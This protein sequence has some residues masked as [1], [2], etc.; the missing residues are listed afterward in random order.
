MLVLGYHVLG[1]KVFEEAAED[2]LHYVLGVNGLGRSF[3]TGLG[4]L[5]PKQIHHRPSASDGVVEPVPGL[6]AGGPNR[7]LSGD[8]V[9]DALINAGTP[10]ALCYAD[11]TPSYASNEIA[12]NWNAPLVFLAGYFSRPYGPAGG[13]R[14][15]EAA[16]QGLRIEQNFPNPFNGSTHIRFSVSRGQHVSLRVSDVL[17]RI[18]SNRRLGSL[19]A[20][21]HDVIWEAKDDEGRPLTSGVYFY[22][23][24]GQG[25]SWVGKLV[26]MR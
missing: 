7:Y 21:T 22:Y 11:S 6:L 14:E 20:G 15:H 18:V 26:L 10:A 23:I 24:A 3:I 25:R 12:V 5:P 16:P 19:G 17:G 8:A 4:S 2:Q 13:V 1:S 9:L